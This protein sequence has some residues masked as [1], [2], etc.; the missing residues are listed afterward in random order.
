MAESFSLSELVIPGTYIRVRAEGLI[1]VGGISVGNVGI[2]GTAQRQKVDDAGKPVVVD[3]KPVFEDLSETQILSDFES[4][5]AF[6]GPYDAFDAGKGKLNLTRAIE[7]L[8]QNGAKTIFA[9]SL[10]PGKSTPAD[11]IAAFNELAKDDVNILVAPQLST[12]EAM[13]VFGSV[14][15]T[16]ENDGKDVIAVVGSDKEAV[17]DVKA[18]MTS[19]DRIILTAPGIIASETVIENGKRVGRDVALPGTYSAAAVGG[20]ISSLAPQSSPTNKVLPGIVQLSRRYSYGEMKQLVQARVL[21]LEQRQGVRVVRG[22]TTDDGAFKQVTTRR[23]TDFAKAGIRQAGNAFIGR[24]NNTRV[25]KALRGAIDGFLTTM[26]QDEALT[27]YTLDVTAS[28]QDE[29]AGRAIVNVVIQP[30]FSIDFV[31]V[32]LV[33]Q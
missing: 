31:A 27:G 23:I 10:D 3:N 7:L 1:S 33:L 14:L 13:A 28:R 16:A 2:V 9:R 19:N 6:Y 24:L 22:V 5:R 25:R 26:V 32:T 12:A 29:I 4:A 21:V 11:Y 15:E 8:Y 20:L 17:A 18:Q 30:T